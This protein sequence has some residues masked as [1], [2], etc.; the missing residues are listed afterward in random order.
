MYSTVHKNESYKLTSVFD[1]PHE[2][3]ASPAYFIYFQFEAEIEI[4]QTAKKKKN[5]NEN[6][7]KIEEYNLLLEKHRD[8]VQKLETILRML[9]N[10]T[11]EI[12][13]VQWT[14]DIRT[15]LVIKWSI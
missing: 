13:Q 12:S 5:K 6:S 4:L 1:A 3:L 15:I 2:K 7:D 8:H 11:V 10:K 14:S 9:D